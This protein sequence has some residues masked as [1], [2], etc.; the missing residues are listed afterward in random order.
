MLSDRIQFLTVKSCINYLNPLLK[1][2]HILK[3]S[4]V[5][6]QIKVH[7]LSDYSRWFHGTCPHKKAAGVSIATHKSLPYQLEDQMK[8]PEGRFIFIKFS[9]YNR[10]F[11]VANFYL[12]K[13]NQTSAGNTYL[14]SLQAFA[15]G[16]T[17]VGGDFNM[18]LDLTIDTTFSRSSI[19]HTKLKSFKKHLFSAQLIEGWRTLHPTTRNYT[20]YS[21]PPTN[22]IAG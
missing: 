11:T 1:W 4:K 7:W 5:I 9:L 14:K 3:I 17:L 19:S 10:S 13:T 16:T 8:D 22:R 2:K 12:P 6:E 21:N 20:F 18:T 15:S